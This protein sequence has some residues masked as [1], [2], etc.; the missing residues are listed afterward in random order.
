MISECLRCGSEKLMHNMPLPDHYGDTGG[1][2]KPAEVAVH[3][4]PEAW[5]FK[6]TS[7]GQVSLT[8]CGECGYAE[9]QVNNFRELYEKHV[10]A[11]QPKEE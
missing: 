4:K 5:I 11:Q 3:G 2:S 10:R 9:L 8:I 7:K 1:F 6:E